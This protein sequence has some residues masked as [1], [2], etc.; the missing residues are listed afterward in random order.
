MVQNTKKVLKSIQ[1]VL[2]LFSIPRWFACLS[3]QSSLDCEPTPADQLVT[4]E[5][6][7]RERVKEITTPDQVGLQ[8]QR[9][10]SIVIFITLIS[11]DYYK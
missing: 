2:N 10:S 1:D 3:L 6:W 8:G 4:L 11:L 5:F 9:W 7:L